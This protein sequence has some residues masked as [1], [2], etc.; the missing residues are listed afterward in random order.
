MST[1]AGSCINRREP[2]LPCSQTMNEIFLRQLPMW[3]LCFRKFLWLW[4][5][6]FSKYYKENDIMS[7]TQQKQFFKPIELQTI[8]LPTQ[9]MWN[10]NGGYLSREKGPYRLSHTFPIVPVPERWIKK[11]QKSKTSMRHMNLY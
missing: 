1:L 10:K 3:I 5:K 11:Y 7:K 2:D 9:H 8:G 4:R 6:K